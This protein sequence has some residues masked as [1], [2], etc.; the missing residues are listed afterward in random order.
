M[1][2]PPPAALPAGAGVA[3]TSST[4]GSSQVMNVVQRHKVNQHNSAFVEPSRQACVDY[5]GPFY[6]LFGQC[7]SDNK[8][9]EAASLHNPPAPFL[10]YWLGQSGQK[11]WNVHCK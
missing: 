5:R 6:M 10:K 11:N 4:V 2:S 3:P 7:C 8:G 9:S 1:A